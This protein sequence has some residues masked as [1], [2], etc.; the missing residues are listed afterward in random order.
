MKDN[1]DGLNGCE[2]IAIAIT[3]LNRKLLC[4]VAT[5][6]SVLCDIIVTIM[7]YNSNT[8]IVSQT[9]IAVS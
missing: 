2:I 4:F 1:N 7:L 8:G 3:Y 9:I 6:L 5:A